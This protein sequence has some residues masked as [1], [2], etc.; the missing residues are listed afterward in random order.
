MPEKLPA[1]ATLA[2]LLNN[3]AVVHDGWRLVTAYS[4]PWQIYDLKN[5]RTETRNLVTECPEK[6]AE[7]VAIQRAFY[8]RPDVS[9]RLG[10]GER[11][12]EYAPPFNADGTKGPGP[13]R[14]R[15]QRCVF[16][17]CWWT[18]ADGREPDAQELETLHQRAVPKGG[19]GAA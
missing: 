1:A 6:L 5:D 9:L 7:L 11:E 12:P 4:Q 19:K 17:A 18:R 14:R 16:A 2:P 3:L 13:R 15:A 10:P 8:A